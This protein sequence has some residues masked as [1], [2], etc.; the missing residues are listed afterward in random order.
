MVIV[1]NTDGKRI[2]KPKCK[3]CNM[4]F[5]NKGPVKTHMVSSHI[6]LHEGK[7]ISIYLLIWLLIQEFEYL[8][9]EN[10]GT[11][12]TAQNQSDT[13]YNDNWF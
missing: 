8:D 2:M 5:T 4:V 7:F 12:N 9:Y 11:E 10:I 13:D 3:I 6:I 1:S